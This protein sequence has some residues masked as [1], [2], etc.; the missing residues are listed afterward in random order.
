MKTLI[1]SILIFIP[2]G[3]FLLSQQVLTT[4]GDYYT[5]SQG[6][7]SWTL[8]EPISETLN[9]NSVLTQGFQQDYENI[10]KIEELLFPHPLVYP[11]PFTNNISIDLNGILFSSTVELKLLDNSGRTILSNPYIET[12]QTS[13]LPPGMYHL[14]L[15]VD[16]NKFYTFKLIKSE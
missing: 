4:S 14:S 10:L 1:C 12:L 8:G 13:D 3:K 9:Q 7:L 2:F 15:I 6:S 5:H 16:Q 11:N